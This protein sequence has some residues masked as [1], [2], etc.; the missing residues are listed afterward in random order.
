M[1]PIYGSDLRYSECLNRQPRAGEELKSE[2]AR[3]V[4]SGEKRIYF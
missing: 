3:L 2:R 1:E 4:V